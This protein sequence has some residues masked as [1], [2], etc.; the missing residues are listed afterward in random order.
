MTTNK[1][2]LAWVNEVADLCHPESIH[3]CDGSEEENQKLL[4]ETAG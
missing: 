2:L 3:W 4:D 1:K